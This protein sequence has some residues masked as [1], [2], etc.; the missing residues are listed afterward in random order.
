MHTK[1]ELNVNVN[2]CTVFFFK[3]GYASM[4]G[5]IQGMMKTSVKKDGDVRGRPSTSRKPQ[6]GQ[7]RPVE[8]LSLVNVD[9]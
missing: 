7:R 2:V 9:Q 3:D 5:T 4:K 8:K 1:G 6:S